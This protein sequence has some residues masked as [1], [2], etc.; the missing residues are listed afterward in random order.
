[1]IIFQNAAVLEIFHAAS[2]IVSSDPI[3]TTFQVMSRVV[4]VCGVLIATYAARASFG[5]TLCLFAW[6]ITEI[7]RYATYTLNLLGGVPFF[8]KWIR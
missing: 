7:I 8:L 6:C 3:L 4:V 5:L 2:R 1:M